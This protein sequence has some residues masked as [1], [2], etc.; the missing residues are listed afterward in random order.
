MEMPKNTETEKPRTF[1]FKLSDAVYEDCIKNIPRINN[2]VARNSGESF[3]DA[4]RR[5]RASFEALRIDGKSVDE[6]IR[7]L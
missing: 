7:D 4:L 1:T 2:S 3:F 6:I 5:N